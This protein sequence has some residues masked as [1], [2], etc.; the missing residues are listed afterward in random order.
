MYKIYLDNIYPIFSSN[1]SCVL[2]FTF[3]FPVSC[4]LFYFYYPLSTFIHT[5][6]YIVYILCISV[7]PSAAH[8]QSTRGHTSE[9]NH[10]SL[11]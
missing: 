2:L 11:P 6:P 10:L 9:E 7:G 1:T 5:Y 3:L 8:E 4:N